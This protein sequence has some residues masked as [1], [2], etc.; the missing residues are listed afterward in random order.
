MA[1]LRIVEVDITGRSDGEIPSWDSASGVHVYTSAGAGNSLSSTLIRRTTAQNVSGSGTETPISFDTE[2]EDTD[3]VWA[4]GTPTKLVI[5]AGL[6]G[7]RAIIFGGGN[8][9]ASTSGNYRHLRIADGGGSPLT[10]DA[11][12]IVPDLATALA[13]ALQVRTH[14]LTLATAQEFTLLERIDA[15]G[16]GVDKAFMGLYTVD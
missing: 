4:I 3:G 15:T 12:M 11:V 6:N 2:D 5:P 9:S 7:R 16:I 8:F 14:V 1:D 10:P 13:I